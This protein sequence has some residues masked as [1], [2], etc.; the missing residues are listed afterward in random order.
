M[1]SAAHLD[2]RCIA[3]VVMDR[4]ARLRAG[5][6][7]SGGRAGARREGGVAILVAL[8]GV[9]ALRRRRR[10]DAGAIRARPLVLK[11]ET[12][13]PLGVVG[14]GVCCATSG[15]ASRAPKTRMSRSRAFD[16]RV[17]A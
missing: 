10:I 17:L 13:V 7:P 6:H 8:S 1:E 5:T 16:E 2:A 9:R 14:L 11:V 15:V 12:A 3:V 4:R